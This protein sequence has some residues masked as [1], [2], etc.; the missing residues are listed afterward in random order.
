MVATTVKIKL[1]HRRLAKELRRK[2]ISQNAWAMR[3][4][5]ESGHL[6]KLVN[7]KRPYPSVDTRR[8]LLRG[9]SLEFEQLFIASGA[10][11]VVEC[12]PGPIS[13]ELSTYEGLQ[14][15]FLTDFKLGVR[16]LI[17]Q[18]LLAISMI[19]LIALGIAANSSIFTVLSA[20]ILQ[21]LPFDEPDRLVQLWRALPAQGA[22][23]LR[24]SVP[25]YFD[26]LERSETLEMIALY[27]RTVRNL[28]G[29]GQPERLP[30]ALVSG[31]F[32]EV[33]G[34][35]AQLGRTFQQSEE[36]PGGERLVMISHAF[37]TQ[38]FASRSD[39]L[40]Q[41]IALNERP[42]TIVGVLPP[43]FQLWGSPLITSIFGF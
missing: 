6:S 2:Q 13:R 34:V 43:A 20:V 38:R 24:T 27:D 21:P 10:R 8:K 16:H 18:P 7:G 41:T 5:L 19:L 42:Y 11:E 28:S 35:Q 37:W 3:L 40:G 33:L 32:F 31:A 23:R 25:E 17:K 36:L 14:M 1:R 30:V 12:F 9:L 29:A 26:L 22:L 39:V 15:S 4:G